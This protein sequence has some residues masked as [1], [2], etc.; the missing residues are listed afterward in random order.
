MV[1]QVGPWKKCHESSKSPAGPLA[2]RQNEIQ[3]RPISGLVG[4]CFKSVL[5]KKF[6]ESSKGPVG[7]LAKRQNLNPKILDKLCSGRVHQD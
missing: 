3:G 2:K 6:H 4:G 1:L 7:P 5:G